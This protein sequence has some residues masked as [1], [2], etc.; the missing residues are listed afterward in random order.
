MSDVEEEE[1]EEERGKGFV[2][3]EE[4]RYIHFSDPLG[5]SVLPFK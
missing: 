1:E 3:L 4:K 2:L 5:D